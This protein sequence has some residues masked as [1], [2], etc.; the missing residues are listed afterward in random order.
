MLHHGLRALCLVALVLVVAPPAEASSPR[1]VLDRLGLLGAHFAADCARPV[2]PQNPYTF[3]RPVDGALVQIDLMVGL[4]QRQYAYVIDRAVALG[5]GGLSISM[6]NAE[7]RLNLAYAL[8]GGRLRTMESA[9][10]GVQVA[11][12]SRG[13]FTAT[14]RPTPWLSRCSGLT[15]ST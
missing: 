10:D 5:R 7:K 9:H 3:F 12:V 4:T 11:I 6:A 8:D 13:V 1:E 14:G 2:S 15:G